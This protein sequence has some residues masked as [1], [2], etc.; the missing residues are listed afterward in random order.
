MV[1]LVVRLLGEIMHCFFKLRENMEIIVN[2]DY[3][4][5]QEGE[6]TEVDNIQDEV[7]NLIK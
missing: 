5:K 7:K 2:K 6:T 1:S 3:T 4:T